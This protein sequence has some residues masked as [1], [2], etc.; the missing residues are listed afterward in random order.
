MF[1]KDN[2]IGFDFRIAGAIIRP[3]SSLLYKFLPILL[4]IFSSY[5]MNDSKMITSGF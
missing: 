1:L 5:F 2:P 4:A 3:G